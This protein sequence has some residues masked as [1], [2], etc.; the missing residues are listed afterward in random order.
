M[1]PLF[2]PAFAVGARRRVAQ[3]LLIYVFAL[4]VGL[5]AGRIVSAGIMY[6]TVGWTATWI[7]ISTWGPS[8]QPEPVSTR[9]S[10][11]VA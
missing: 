5:F 1:A 8:P 10:R 4:I 9:A 7:E 3:R 6:A 11:A 2:A